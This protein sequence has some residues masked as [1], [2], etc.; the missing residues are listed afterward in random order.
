MVSACSSETLDGFVL[1]ALLLTITLLIK[2]YFT[3]F[4]SNWHVFKHNAWF[5]I[6]RVYTISVSSKTWENKHTADFLQ[7]YLQEI[8]YF[9]AIYFAI[10]ITMFI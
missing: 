6:W 10:N 8:L 1:P 3:L 2:T 5:V 7:S 9:S 4:C